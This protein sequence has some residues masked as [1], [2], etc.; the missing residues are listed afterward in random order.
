MLLVTDKKKT[1]TYWFWTKDVKRKY[2]IYLW[3]FSFFMTIFS[4]DS[5]PVFMK[6]VQLL[7]H[8]LGR[9]SDSSFSMC[10]WE[11][12]DAAESFDEQIA[13]AASRLR[14]SDGTLQR[15]IGNMT[16]A[17]WATLSGGLN[18][19]WKHHFWREIAVH[20]RLLLIALIFT[21][22]FTITCSP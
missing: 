19:S 5:L 4:K 15:P 9:P 22:T 13:S 12:W 17:F 7:T 6:Q 10:L 20:I 18:G 8:D 1:F 3:F 16:P 2:F 11:L 21:M 14:S